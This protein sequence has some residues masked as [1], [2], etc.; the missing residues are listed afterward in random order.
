VSTAENMIRIAA[1]EINPKTV[2]LT[3]EQHNT[4]FCKAA[5][6]RGWSSLSR[7]EATWDRGLMGR[8]AERLERRSRL[9]QEASLHRDYPAYLGAR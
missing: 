7:Q 4:A 8:Q 5:S 1:L 6:K 2:R 9:L 3:Y